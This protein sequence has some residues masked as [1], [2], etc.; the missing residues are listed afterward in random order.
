MRNE[1]GFSVAD[2]LVWGAVVGVMLTIIGIASIYF[3]KWREKQAIMSEY[4][5]I[6]TGLDTYRQDTLRYPSGSGWG[7]NTNNAYVP[8]EVI[9]RG[10]QYSC[11]GNTITIT[12][13]AITNSKILA[14]VANELSYKCDSVSTSGNSVVCQLNNR[15]CQ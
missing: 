2:L 9:N 13:P 15:P 8:S 7:W 4:S 6:L 11:S 1:K 3:S 14:S 10:W 5:M 12:T